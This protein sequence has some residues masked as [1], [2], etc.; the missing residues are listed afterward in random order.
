MPVPW[1]CGWIAGAKSTFA[2]RR[3]SSIC[4][5]S[6]R[7]LFV[8]VPLSPEIKARIQNVATSVQQ[9]IL[10]TAD[11]RRGQILKF[12]RESDFHITLNFLG[13]VPPENVDILSRELRPCLMEIKPFRLHLDVL[14]TFPGTA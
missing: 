4:G 13:N 8:A 12:V 6:T 7:R 3:K 11:Q 14:G 1:A 2:D 5:M 10:A 9:G